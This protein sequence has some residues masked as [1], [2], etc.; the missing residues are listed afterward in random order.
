MTDF[1]KYDLKSRDMYGVALGKQWYWYENWIKVVEEF[2]KKKAPHIDPKSIK[3]GYYPQEIV[4][5]MVQLGYDQFSMRDFT[6]FWR[7]ILKINKE[8]TTY[9]YKMNNNRFVWNEK[10][11]KKIKEY[12]SNNKEKF[13]AL[14]ED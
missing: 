1:W 8:N 4:T 14:Y 2:C 7:D 11:L 10:F 3:K 12:C 6:T 13:E 9:G 5:K